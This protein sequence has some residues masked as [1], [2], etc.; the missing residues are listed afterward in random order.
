M[1]FAKR[2][3]VLTVAL[4]ILLGCGIGAFTFF[5]TFDGIGQ[6]GSPPAQ[7]ADPGTHRGAGAARAVDPASQAAPPAAAEAG[8]GGVRAILASVAMWT[9]R[10]AL[11]FLGFIAV[12]C[13][14]RM[15][16]RHR[17]REV[18]RYR[19]DVP[20]T[21]RPDNAQI[22][23]TVAALHRICQED[24]GLRR[25]VFGQPYVA[26]EATSA[27]AFDERRHDLGNEQTMSLVCEPRF[28]GAFDRAIAT[29]WPN[30]RVGYT[31]QGPP[32]PDA[33]VLWWTQNMTRLRKIR[34]GILTSLGD[35]ERGTNRGQAQ[36]LIDL[37]LSTAAGTG[38]H[39]TVQ[40]RLT[41]TTRL[42]EMFLRL[43]ARGRE[44]IEA[45]D[46]TGVTGYLARRELEEALPMRQ[47]AVFRGELWVLGEDRDATRA[48]AG[49]LKAADGPNALEDRKAW[50]WVH[51]RRVQRALPGFFAGS[52]FSANEV[53]GMWALPTLEAQAPAVCS[54]TPR[55]DPEGVVERARGAADAVVD[56][57]LGLVKL[58]AKEKQKGVAI[59]GMPG[60]GKS[61]VAVRLCGEAS[62][63]PRRALVVLDP[64][65]E[66]VEHILSIIP[67]DRPVWTLDL[68]RPTFG[69][70]PL[71]AD[72]SADAIA[73]AFVEG[74]RD[75]NDDGAVQTSS[76]R[77]LLFSVN[78]ELLLAAEDGRRPSLHM[79]I[80][81]LDPSETDLHHRVS[82][83]AMLNG[84]TGAANFWGKQLPTDLR[85]QQSNT[86]ARM[87]APR[88]KLEAL[89][90]TASIDE[91]FHHPVRL[92]L[93]AL[94][95]SRGILLVKGSLGS[96]G[97]ESAAT[98]LKMILRLVFARLQ[99]QQ[100]LSP[101]D[102]TSI[103][104]VVDE[105]HQVFTPALADMAATARSAGANIM[106]AWQNNAQ[107]P[108][109]VVRNAVMS[110]FSQIFV[111]RCN[112]EDAA[113]FAQKMASVF[114][115]GVRDNPG[116]RQMQ[117]V[118]PDMLA[119]LDEHT[120]VAQWVCQ[121]RVTVPFTVRSIP[122][123]LDGN[124]L[125]HH[126]EWQLQRPLEGGKP[127]R[128]DPVP[129]PMADPEDVLGMEDDDET[130]GNANASEFNPD[131][132]RTA[133]ATRTDAPV[134]EE[135]TPGAASEEP[136]GD[137]DDTSAHAEVQPEGADADIDEDPDVADDSEEDEAED[138]D[139]EAL[140]DLVEPDPLARLN[141]PQ[142]I[143]VAEW[144][145]IDDEPEPEPEPELETEPEPVDEPE[146]A[147][148]PVAVAAPGDAT[149]A[150]DEP[151]P[152]EEPAVAEND[153][154]VAT[155]GPAG[156]NDA[157]EPP[158]ADTAVTAAP[159]QEGDNDT[160][161]GD[162]DASPQTTP[163]DE[164]PEG[165]AGDEGEV[166]TP[167]DAGAVE[168]AAPPVEWHRDT[169]DEQY[170]QPPRFFDP[171]PES[172]PSKHTGP[173]VNRWIDPDT[174]ERRAEREQEAH[175]RRAKAASDAKGAQEARE[176][177]HQG[178]ARGFMELDA[179]EEIIGFNRYETDA[180]PA[181]NTRPETR[182]QMQEICRLLARANYLTGPQIGRFFGFKPRQVGNLVRELQ[183][184]GWVTRHDPLYPESRATTPP[185][186][187][188]TRKGFRDTIAG[189]GRRPARAWEELEPVMPSNVMHDVRAAAWTMAMVYLLTPG[190][191]N[192]WFGPR[193]EE[194]TI[195]VPRSRDRRS[196]TGNITHTELAMPY[197][198]DLVLDHEAPFK[199]IKPDALIDALLGA[200]DPAAPE[201]RRRAHFCI[202]YN[203][204]RRP[205]QNLPKIVA[206]DQWFT[207]WSRAMPVY[208][209]REVTPA[210]VFVC[211][212]EPE[213]HAFATLADEHVTGAVSAMGKEPD[214]W[215][216]TARPRMFF[217]AERDAYERSMRVLAIP[218]LPPKVRGQAPGTGI[219]ERDL[220][221]REIIVY[222]GETPTAA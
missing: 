70:N 100:E 139:E 65:N 59:I 172:T 54:G 163:L 133:P 42:E 121:G 52:L 108:D 10:V 79:M 179:L 78:G 110:L 217:A 144:E 91:T 57:S 150:G 178:A 60:V 68:A 75:V 16:G 27:P 193:S 149:E 102:R 80:R 117:R 209:G 40:F 37:A 168:E 58:R 82:R 53:G 84:Q 167:A 14:T 203:H 116:L 213:A 28:V 113:F 202:E 81:L 104:I 222:A 55:L 83:L 188:L 38:T 147:D 106:G 119:T 71:M 159:T 67:R 191:V 143:E 216:Y 214:E 24:N 8:Q 66:M 31:F 118:T 142:D 161:A 183:A 11:S 206:Y 45:D 205:E 220:V 170:A 200:K 115:S 88:N 90:A 62:L 5:R 132:P 72:A 156:T 22:T 130:F 47:T 23:R 125:V 17:R 166:P 44:R 199:N 7:V 218:G 41:P 204:A 219:L 73:D 140:G 96:V 164:V 124:R 148:E 160:E 126:L 69:I 145:P 134:V 127:H 152:D 36:R 176:V 12:L 184:R 103:D 162:G 107:F 94:V 146:A 18:A 101:G 187:T 43:R 89:M 114:E 138:E 120:G 221:P 19:I 154:V 186:L 93:D 181:K 13:G 6:A 195:N 30:A 111:F 165:G 153:P 171:E 194:C 49:A 92:D 51:R 48:V 86:A 112:T 97:Q 211:R 122:V 215:R 207:G 189:P 3:A 180:Q 196:G 39:V 123:Q 29:A 129:P 192:N 175:E 173:V 210:V 105:A 201:K 158:A 26:L 35:G 198:Y 9:V 155:A 190:V 33:T 77:Y 208:S 63:D 76:R 2:I 1:G 46:H 95:D 137:G 20:R 136:D 182:A 177:T 151:A 157:P 85:T 34:S 74:I 56:T 169:G 21:D 128:S 61:T 174:A 141:A 15:W 32:V 4:V 131:E 25:F 64:K 99:R 109:P 185:F 212:D 98:V 197:G 87:T 50:S 135:A